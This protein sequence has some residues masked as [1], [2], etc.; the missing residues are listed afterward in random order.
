MQRQR[1]LSGI[2]GG[3]PN[4]EAQKYDFMCGR[5]PLM[6]GGLSAIAAPGRLRFRSLTGWVWREAFRIIFLTTGKKGSQGQARLL[7]RGQ[8][9]SA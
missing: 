9:T 3:G 6:R 8:K 7:R 2:A 4:D 5:S 1:K